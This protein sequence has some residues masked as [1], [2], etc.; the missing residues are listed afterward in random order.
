MSSLLLL[1]QIFNSIRWWKGVRLNIKKAQFTQRERG[2][3]REMLLNLVHNHL[4][5]YCCYVTLTQKPLWCGLHFSGVFNMMTIFKQ[6]AFFVWCHCA[7]CLANSIQSEFSTKYCEN[8]F[9][10]EVASKYFLLLWIPSCALIYCV[11]SIDTRMSNSFRNV[12]IVRLTTNTTGLLLYYAYL[13]CIPSYSLMKIIREIVMAY[14]VLV[15][16]R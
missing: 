7:H 16:L 10:I 15:E 1:S 2:R 8:I 9:A 3:E 4:I 12:W 6:R 14:Q 5:K 11:E 13:T